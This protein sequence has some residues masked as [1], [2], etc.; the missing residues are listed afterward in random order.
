W[1]LP[2]GEVTALVRL[3]EVDDVGV[4]LLDPAARGPPDLPGERREAGRN[5]DRRGSLAGRPGIFLPFFP[6]GARSRRPGACQ[7]IQ[8]DVVDDVFWGEAARGLPP[9]EGAGDLLV[10]V[11]IVIDH[12]RRQ[13]DG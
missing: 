9:R 8:G 4:G 3:V 12:P 1:F 13:R 11:G 7:P 10:A 5:R 2:G 6:V